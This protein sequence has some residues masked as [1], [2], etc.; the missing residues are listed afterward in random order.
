MYIYASLHMLW[1]VMYNYMYVCMYVFFF[2]FGFDDKIFFD[3]DSLE[4]FFF[5]FQVLIH[6][7][8]GGVGLV[9]IEY[10]KHVGAVVFA[11]AGAEEN[12]MPL[13]SR[14]SWK[15]MKKMIM[16]LKFYIELV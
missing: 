16:Y 10:A 9:A 14:P 4:M 5:V 11:T 2:S 12:G 1:Y 15:S 7:A 6:A 13:D 8:A 3:S